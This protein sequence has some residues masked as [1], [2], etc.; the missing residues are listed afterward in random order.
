MFANL[1]RLSGWTIFG[2]VWNA[3]FFLLEAAFVVLG[4]DGVAII[5]MLVFAAFFLWAC[6]DAKRDVERAKVREK[7]QADLEKILSGKTESKP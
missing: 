1:K 4:H 7:A 3:L 6:K 2:L 5:W